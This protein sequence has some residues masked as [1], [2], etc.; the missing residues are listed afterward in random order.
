MR[1]ALDATPLTLS[2][3]GLTRYTQEVARALAS[4][5]PEDEY[6]LIS[7]AGR[8]LWWSWR[9]QREM[10]RRGA[11]LFHG[12]NF[13]VPYLPARPSVISLHDLSPWMDPGWHFAAQRVRQ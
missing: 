5:F 8:R 2:S 3:G 10:D 12:T 6:C 13:E 7:S 4:Q 9:V 1:V 11:T